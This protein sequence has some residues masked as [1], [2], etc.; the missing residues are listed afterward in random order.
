MLN[1][2]QNSVKKKNH[3]V[4]LQNVICFS[5]D[6]FPICLGSA[7]SFFSVNHYILLFFAKNFQNQRHGE[8]VSWSKKKSMTIK[9]FLLLLLYIY[10]AFSSSRHSGKLYKW[11]IFLAVNTRMASEHWSSGLA[12]CIW[13]LWYQ[14]H[15][16]KRFNASLLLKNALVMCFLPD[17]SV[18]T[19]GL[20]THFWPMRCL[21]R[22][23][24]KV[25]AEGLANGARCCP[26]H[27]CS[28]L[29]AN[30]VLR[31]LFRALASVTISNPVTGILWHDT[32]VARCSSQYTK[33]KALASPSEI[34]TALS[35]IFLGH[36]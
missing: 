11:L 23:H 13:K 4:R 28:S 29:F 30:C 16:L 34:T 19:S 1:I 2:Y 6:G 33:S 21:Q 18:K 9:C 24:L 3:E 26:W 17:Q 5:K 10:K 20:A 32:V 15:F 12:L 27:V 31:L 35:L 25:F 22:R 7:T 14:I 36:S 8:P